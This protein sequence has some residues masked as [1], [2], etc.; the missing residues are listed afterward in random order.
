[1]NF[2]FYTVV[3]IIAILLL[4]ISLVTLGVIITNGSTSGVFPPVNG[5]SACPDFWTLSSSGSC[6]P[7]GQNTGTSSAPTSVPTLNPSKIC[8]S[9]KI[10]KM[11]NIFWDGVWNNNKCTLSN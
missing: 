8:D 1:M 5:I 11:Y 7:N 2:D 9:Y 3:S 6:Q 10:S 4:I